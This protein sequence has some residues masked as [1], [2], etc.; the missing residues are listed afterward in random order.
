MIPTGYGFSGFSKKIYALKF[1]LLDNWN[2]IVSDFF[3]HFILAGF[4]N[5]IIIN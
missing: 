3:L 2:N 4:Q 1:F 5:N